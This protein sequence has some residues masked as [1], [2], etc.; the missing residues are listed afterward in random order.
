MSRIHVK[1]LKIAL[2]KR[3]KMYNFKPWA[4]MD[5][6][7]YQFSRILKRTRRR[8]TKKYAK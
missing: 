5:K 4:M 2:K 7:N 6:E 8:N 1:S 3:N